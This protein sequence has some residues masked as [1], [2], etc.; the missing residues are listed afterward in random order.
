MPLQN[1]VSKNLPA[2]SAAWLNTVD[3]LKF[4]VFGD[5]AT[6]VA[7]R[8]ALELPAQLISQGTDTGA[9]NAAVVTL[10][11]PVTG[12]VRSTGVAIAFRATAVNTGA[13][14]VNVNG[15]GA[16]SILNQTG[17]ALTGGELSVPVI[18]QWT[19]AAWQIIQGS[20]TPLQAR[21]TASELVAL[22]MPTNFIPLPID[23]R[24]YGGVGDGV[25]DDT[26]AFI[27]AV[28][29]AVV[30]GGAIIF[31]YDKN[32]K[33]AIGAQVTISSLFPVHLLSFMS[34]NPNA[35]GNSTYIKPLNNIA[36]DMIK[37]S[38]P[39]ASPNEC[40]GGTIY[41]LSFFDD[42]DPTNATIANRRVK[43][44]NAALGLDAFGLSKAIN[45][46]FHY[47]K[48]S[49][50]RVGFAA[51]TDF[52]GNIVRY[53]GTAAKPAFDHP[54][55]ASPMQSCVIAQNRFEVCFDAPYIYIHNNTNTKDN[56]LEANGFE[57]D[58]AIAATSQFYI[59]MTASNNVI[60]IC[61]FDRLGATYA[62]R[63]TGQMNELIGSIADLND[64]GLVTGAGNKNTVTG[65]K[66]QATTSTIP[67]IDMTGQDCTING[68]TLY[69]ANKIALSGIRA[70]VLNAKLIDCTTPDYLITATAA[71]YEISNIEIANTNGVRAV[72]PN[73]ISAAAEGKVAFCRLLGNAAATGIDV[74]SANV[75]CVYNTLASGYTTP[76]NP[77]GHM[78]D[79][80][81]DHNVGFVT[82]AKGQAQ[83]TAAVT[84]VVINHGLGFTPTLQMITVVPLGNWLAT[85]KWWISTVTATQFTINVDIAPGGAGLF[86]AWKIAPR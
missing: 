2:I 80:D 18:I 60:S 24:R 73:G 78:S 5:A 32:Y 6:K 27:R 35:T 62:V 20:I 82:A 81:I 72:S 25:T 21:I 22:I 19:G 64:G 31:P 53:C 40:G 43:T 44:V 57:S 26:P 8:T 75:D 68:T 14:T 52:I 30:G 70:Q 71:G 34:S 48:G 54:A 63:F 42:T 56:K 58:T 59:D 9:V 49:A 23:I 11:G 46:Y 16:A 29:V 12:F 39:T 55:G 66:V 69:F 7:A 51:M 45:C 77:N 4:S 47:I 15:T 61:H 86:F 67:T 17:A 1:F 85:T 3:V 76:I 41:G 84:T 28:S 13:A 74:S 83:V 10:I 79:S 65:G 36:G 37:Y 50:M 38:S 33:W